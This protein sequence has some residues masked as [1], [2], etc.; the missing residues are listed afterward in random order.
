MPAIARRSHTGTAPRRHPGTNVATDDETGVK[1]IDD[2]DEWRS[3]TISRQECSFRYP[4]EL[5]REQLARHKVRT[6]KVA[7]LTENEFRAQST[8][9]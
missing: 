6:P 1:P 7:A 5:C 9:F 3:F 2:S 8:R 4:L